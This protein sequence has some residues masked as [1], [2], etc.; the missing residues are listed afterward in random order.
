[1][2]ARGGGEAGWGL[3]CSGRVIGSFGVDAPFEAAEV[4]IEAILEAEDRPSWGE[5]VFDGIGELTL[6]ADALA[7]ADGESVVVGVA[8]EFAEEVLSDEEGEVLEAAT[9]G[10]F[11]GLV[12]DFAGGE[13]KEDLGGGEWGDGA[14]EDVWVGGGAGDVQGDVITEVEAGGLEGDLG[15]EGVFA[16]EADATVV[17]VE[18]AEGEADAAFGDGDVAEGDGF[19]EGAGELDSGGDAALEHWGDDAEE[20]VAF[21]AHVQSPVAP[22]GLFD[23]EEGGA[24]GGRFDI[25]ADEGVEVAE[26]EAIVEVDDS[27]DG[28]VGEGG[29]GEFESDGAA[30][31]EIGLAGEGEVG[32]GE[33]EVEPGLV[34]GSGWVEAPGAGEADGL[35]AEVGVSVLELKGGGVGEDGGVDLAERS[36]WGEGAGGGVGDD[37]GGAGAEAGLEVGGEIEGALGAEDVGEKGSDGGEVPVGE[38]EVGFEGLQEGAVERGGAVEEGVEVEG[39]GG[40]EDAALAGHAHFRL[41]AEQAGWFEV[42]FQLRLVEGGPAGL[43]LGGGREER[44]E[45]AGLEAELGGGVGAGAGELEVKGGV[46]EEETPSRGE[47]SPER[48]VGADG[49]VDFERVMGAEADEGG[50][51]LRMEGDRD[52]SGEGAYGFAIAA[53]VVGVEADFGWGGV[54]FGGG[55]ECGVGGRLEREGGAG[56]EFEGA[57]GPTGRHVEGI[58]GEPGRGVGEEG[59]EVV[60]VQAFDGEL[61]GSGVGAVEGGGEVEVAAVADEVEAGDGDVEGGGEVGGG[62]ELVP[63]RAGGGKQLEDGEFLAE[64]GEGG[65]V[66]DS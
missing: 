7:A 65:E 17:H 60:P 36:E 12:R 8:G 49:E 35:A 31:G 64:P 66:E 29:S 26:E 48:G 16:G 3:D 61:E 42:D 19:A 51:F 22:G 9:G 15:D 53:E 18:S 1:M 14:E 4:G 44:M 5:A 54:D 11:E 21:H 30:E 33:G 38:L 56:L 40:V 23:T 47:F 37:E 24:A 6:V 20:A 50:G 58:E 10:V 59:A 28:G 55:L 39:E 46:V 62:G 52:A 57:V 32:S 41:S 63:F 45:A 43:G 27:G 2:G 13:H 34:V 25:P